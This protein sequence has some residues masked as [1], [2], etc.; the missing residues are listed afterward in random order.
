MSQCNSCGAE[1]TWVYTT[2]GKRMPIDNEAV[3]NGNLVLTGETRRG[4]PVVAYLKRGDP[5][6][7]LDVARL[8]SHFA[9]CP[10]A[11]QHRR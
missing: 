1:I 5:Q 7:P 3:E 10:N 4:S 2:N 11:E 8:V 6:L 9:T